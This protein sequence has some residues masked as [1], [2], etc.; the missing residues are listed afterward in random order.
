MNRQ[1]DALFGLEAAAALAERRARERNPAY[2]STMEDNALTRILEQ[3]KKEQI[4]QKRHAE[5]KEAADMAEMQRMLDA[6]GVLLAEIG[7]PVQ[8]FYVNPGGEVIVAKRAGEAV[9]IKQCH[10][11]SPQGRRI[12]VCR[13]IA[14]V[15]GY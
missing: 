11:D 5:E 7:R 4:E 1:D 8:S 9:R 3:Q 15:A 10:I 2:P 12:V 13:M 6:T 14:A